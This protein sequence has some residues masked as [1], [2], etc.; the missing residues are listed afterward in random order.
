MALHRFSFSTLFLLSLTLL[1]TTTLSLSTVYDLLPKYGLPSGLLPD[2]VT[3]FTLSDDGLFVVRLARSCEIEFDYRVRYDKTVS[4]RISYGS[5]TELEGIQVKRL[6]IWLDVDEIKVDLPPTDSIYFKVGF[7]NKKL[8]IDQFKTVH[9]CGVSGCS[10]KSFLQL[11][12]MMNEAVMLITESTYCVLDFLEFAFPSQSFDLFLFGVMVGALFVVGS[13]VMD[14]CLCKDAHTRSKKK[15]LGSARKLELGSSFAGSGIVFRLSS[16]RV[17]R[18]ANRRSKRKLLIVNEDVAGNY[19]DT[20]GDVKTQLIN[21]FTYK[22]VRT[23]LHQLY[24]MN[25]PRYTWFY[26]YVVSNRPTDGKRFLRKL[27]KK[28]TFVVSSES[29]ENQELAERVMITRL[30]LYGKWIKK[31]DHGKIYQDISDENLAL[32]RERLMETV[33]W[34]SDDSSSEV[35]G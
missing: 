15:I 27:G 34:P 4:G 6:F 28:S 23:V 5:I 35:I 31:C 20:F 14:S 19:D 3:N 9:S 11:P 10:W 24:E 2:S 32:M 21:Y 29:F 30:H 1:T 25:P 17:P 18:I 7:I 26:N 12:G 8:G 22:A 33:I 13:S 16:K